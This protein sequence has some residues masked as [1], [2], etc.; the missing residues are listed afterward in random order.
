[1]DKNTAINYIKAIAS[2]KILSKDEVDSAYD[3]GS[4]LPVSASGINQAAH[5]NI[6]FTGILYMIGACIVLIGIV[7][8]IS[9]HWDNLSSV[10]RILATLGFAIV[11][12]VTGVLLIGENKTHGIAIAS[13]IIAAALF[14]TG[15][16]VSIYEYGIT[17]PTIPMVTSVSALLAA[18]YAITLYF[19][20]NRLFAVILTVYATWFMYMLVTY[21]VDLAGIYSGL[22]DI[23]EYV[24]IALG[25]GY[26]LIGNSIASLQNYRRLSSLYYF[27]GSVAVYTSVMILSGWEPN[28]SYLYEML[29]PFI[30]VGGLYLSVQFVSRA[31]LA[32]SALALF[33]YI[34]KI[35]S[36]YFSDALGWPFALIIAG[37]AMIAGGYFI[38]NIRTKLKS[39]IIN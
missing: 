17:N 29:Y 20:K 16:F 36:E 28:Q 39:K 14:P 34:A 13:H 7:V 5:R 19:W 30:V 24:T 8:L 9:T 22:S 33:A 12:Y 21:L 27:A 1:M 38:A 3:Q 11:F 15:I 35:T 23:Y 31:L 2:A 26:I 25:A 37:I 4:V 6:N 32:T 18:L 10:I